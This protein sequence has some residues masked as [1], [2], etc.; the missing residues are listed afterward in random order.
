MT[1]ALVDNLAVLALASS[2]DF[3]AP[4]RPALPASPRSFLKPLHEFLPGRGAGADI[5]YRVQD[6][7]LRTDGEPVGMARFCMPDPWDLLRSGLRAP[8]FIEPFGELSIGGARPLVVAGDFNDVPGSRTIDLFDG[9]WTRIPKAGESPLT[10]PSPGPVREIDFI[11]ARGRVRAPT[12]RA[13]VIDERVASDHRPVIA[14]IA[15]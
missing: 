10:F 5:R 12:A 2:F 6:V 1:G 14:T 7:I 3:D 8:I 15:W 9:A 13:R 4:A 11:Y